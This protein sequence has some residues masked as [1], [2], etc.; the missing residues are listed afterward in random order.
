MTA[1]A[2]GRMSPLLMTSKS[3]STPSETVVVPVRALLPEVGLSTQVPAPI[4]WRLVVAAGSRLVM[5][6]S[7]TLVPPRTKVF[8]PVL[9]VMAPLMV[10]GPVPLELR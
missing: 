8:A 4:F 3:L 10:S 1:E 5:V 7:P 6:L 9:A 2:S